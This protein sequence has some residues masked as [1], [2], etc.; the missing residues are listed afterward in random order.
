MRIACDHCLFLLFIALPIPGDVEPNSPS[1]ERLHQTPSKSTAQGLI[2]VKRNLFESAEKEAPQTQNGGEEATNSLVYNK[3][4]MDIYV[5]PNETE[6][7][8]RSG[9]STPQPAEHDQEE[10]ENIVCSPALMQYHYMTDNIKNS[11]SQSEDT[12]ANKAESLEEY[13]DDDDDDLFIEEANVCS[14]DALYNMITQKFGDCDSFSNI[15]GNDSELKRNLMI[16]S[17]GSL[18]QYNG[19]DMASVDAQTAEANEM[20]MAIGGLYLRNPRGGWSSDDLRVV[21]MI[22]ELS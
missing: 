11:S 6:K 8:T 4:S 10:F 9:G 18:S 13:D 22:L 14:N 7:V 1:D 17:V 5:K 19:S 15:S 12:R 16:S 21:L 3:K 2:R 20:K